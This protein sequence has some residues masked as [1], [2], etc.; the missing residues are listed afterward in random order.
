MTVQQLLKQ[1]IPVGT[2]TRGSLVMIASA[3]ASMKCPGHTLTAYGGSKGFVKSFCIQLSQEFA[4]SGIRVNSVSPGQVFTYSLR[5]SKIANFD[6]SY[7]DTDLNRAVAKIRPEVEH[8]FREAPPLKRIGQPKDV[9]GGVLYLLSD[10]ASYVTGHD[11]AID[12]GMSTG[13]GLSQ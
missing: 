11:L 3:S 1:P 5:S 12:G 4:A 9:A 7:V 13:T 10:T 6:N 2:N 8:Y